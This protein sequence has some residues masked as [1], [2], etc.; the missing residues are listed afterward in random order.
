MMHLLSALDAR[1]NVWDIISE[2]KEF[3]HG[4]IS[5][6]PL[7]NK[8]LAMVFEKASTRTRMSFE[9]GMYQLGGQPLYLSVT[10]MGS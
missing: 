10:L 4:N 2:A 7:K 3:K 6:K 5:K 8:S 1:N 9:V